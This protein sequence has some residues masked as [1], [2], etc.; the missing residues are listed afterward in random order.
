MKKNLSPWLNQLQR[1]RE[2]INLNSNKQADVLIVGAGIAGV[3]TSYFLLENTNKKIIIIDSHKAGHGASGHNAGQ[4]TT[5]FERPLADIATEFGI[6]LACKGQDDVENAWGLLD[7]FSERINLKTPIYKFTGYAGMTELRQVLLHLTDNMIRYDGG[8][9][10][11]RMLISDDFE[12]L[13]QIPSTYSHLYELITKDNLLNLLETENRDYVA[14]LAYKKGATNSA[15][16]C[17]EAINYFIDKHPE[18]FEIFENSPVSKIFLNCKG[19]LSNIVSGESASTITSEKVILCT[20]GFEGFDLINEDG[21][22]INTK[23]HHEVN[24]RINYMSAYIDNISEDPVAI[25]YFPKEDLIDANKETV[26]GEQ[27]FYIT[28][29]PHLHNGEEMGLISTGGPEKILEE[30]DLYDRD[31]LCEDWAEKAI[32]T[33]LKANYRKHKNELVEY[34]FCWHGLLGYTTTGIRI[35]GEEPNNKNLI[36]NLGCNGI[37][38]MPSIHG[39]QKVSRIINGE[40]LEKSIFD[41]K[42]N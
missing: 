12:H 5:Y 13:N 36:Y 42:A 33:F 41:P 6:E 26:S 28:R 38:I 23:F 34:D 39:A 37:G 2:I 17:E 8:L 35:I 40:T 18:R 25:S 30:G 24:G 32:D 21:K 11:E 27:Y 20:N 9:A 3:M 15:K 31:D 4:L 14:T 16:I 19:V 29:R 10:V 7:S 22:D 1:T